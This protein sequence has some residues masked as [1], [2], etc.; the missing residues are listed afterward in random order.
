[1]DVLIVNKD[2]F[3]L[4][5]TKLAVIIDVVVSQDLLYLFIIFLNS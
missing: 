5:K 3:E 1:V 2:A 4:F